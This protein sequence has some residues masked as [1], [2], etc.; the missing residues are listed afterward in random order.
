MN[1]LVHNAKK[2]WSIA[3]P[4]ILS[5]I[6]TSCAPEPTSVPA[7]APAASSGAIQ[8]PAA[9]AS[10]TIDKIVKNGKLRIGVAVAPPWLLQD[11]ATN[12]YFGPAVDISE[13]IASLL[14][15]E[16]EYVPSNWDVLIAGLQADKFDLAGAP[17]FA[18]E[19]RMKVIDFMSYT[20]AG[21]C[22]FVKKDNTKINSLS[23]LNDPS[24]T[25][26]TFTGTGT[27]EG[28]RKSYPKAIIRS[29]VQPP[30]GQPPI[31]EILADRG[32]VGPM[33]SPIMVMV[34]SKYP[35][36]RIIGGADNCFANP[37]IPFPIGLGFNKGD[38]GLTTFLK[39]VVDSM[40]KDINANILKYSDPKYMGG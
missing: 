16:V 12:K 31:E 9:G 11:P 5:V 37:D 20:S 2:F 32:V 24:V 3:V 29:I 19:A 4:V 27:E 8:A 15:V 17:M 25:I 40:Q 10:A 7:A 28:I 18:T 35:D 1:T 13:K 21:T 14:N 22:Y 33:D 30:G 26:V 39:L 36:L 34:Q 6:A 38:A 23:D